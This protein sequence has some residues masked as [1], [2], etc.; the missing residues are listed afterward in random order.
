MTFCRPDPAFLREHNRDRFC[1][2]QVLF[3][4]SLRIT[5]HHDLANPIVT[6]GFSIFHQLF[7]DERFQPGLRLN[8]FLKVGSF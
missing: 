2:Y 3:C 4:K 7:F 6:E 5:A 1:R 8:R